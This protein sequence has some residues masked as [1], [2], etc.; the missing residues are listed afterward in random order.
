[1]ETDDRGH[2]I[3]NI[4]DRLTKL[5]S[6]IAWTEQRSITIGD[7]FIRLEVQIAT[8]L[9]TFSSFFLN[10]FNN[11]YLDFASSE[12]LLVM[13]LAFALSLISLLIS[14]TF[15]LL[16][17]KTRERFCDQI[18]KQRVLRHRKWTEALEKDTTFKEALAYEDGSKLGP[19]ITVAEPA[20]TWILQSVCLAVGVVGLLTLALIFLFNQ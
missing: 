15:G 5:S 17:I 20:W 18:L 6:G 2:E 8:I 4:R 7:E 12:T 10:K 13:R 14:L 11:K 19:G 3:Q 9:F 16:H 1:M